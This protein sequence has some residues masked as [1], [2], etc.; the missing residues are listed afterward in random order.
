MSAC[1]LD[2]FTW[3]PTPFI[4][5]TPHLALPAP[6]YVPTPSPWPATAI[7]PLVFTTSGV[8][9]GP[10][11]VSTWLPNGI[12]VISRSFDTVCMSRCTHNISLPPGSSDSIN[13]IINVSN[14]FGVSMGSIPQPAPQSVRP[15]CWHRSLS[16][17]STANARACD[18]A[19]S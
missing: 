13:T 4:S 8:S 1:T 7:L 11:G 5:F 9:V 6:R 16:I 10:F 18:H 2:A 14:S 19:A 15:H 17:V 12:C 3:L